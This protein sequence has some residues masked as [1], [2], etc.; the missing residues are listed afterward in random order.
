MIF[1][2]IETEL[3]FEVCEC[4][5]NQAPV[6]GQ[7]RQDQG[8]LEPDFRSWICYQ[9]NHK[10]GPSYFSFFIIYIPSG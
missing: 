3:Q 9:A 7:Y 5:L 1:L 6:R 2:E 4:Q 10:A 8:S